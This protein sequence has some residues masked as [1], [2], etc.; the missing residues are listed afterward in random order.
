MEK[1]Q[2]GPPSS[3]INWHKHGCDIM[4]SCIVQNSDVK[5]SQVQVK[6]HSTLA[7]INSWS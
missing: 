4:Y 2:Y 3:P 7:I 1:K 5:Y 6:A